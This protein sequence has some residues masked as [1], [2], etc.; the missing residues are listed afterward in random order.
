M[1]AKKDKGERQRKNVKNQQYI[2]IND[3]DG[4]NRQKKIVL[5]MVVWIYKE[6]RRESW[7]CGASN[8]QGGFEGV[9]CMGRWIPRMGHGLQ[10]WKISIE[11]ERPNVKKWQYIFMD[12]RNDEGEMERNS[13]NN[14]LYVIMDARKDK[15]QRQR[16]NVKNW[17]YIFINDKGG[18]NRQKKIVLKMVVL[19][20]KER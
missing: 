20:Y 18:M 3:K 10:I 1:N 6:K 12:G 7:R 17:Q 8:N 19:V 4:M 14:W 2:F 9:K 11:T 16:K 5:K 13:V 15:D